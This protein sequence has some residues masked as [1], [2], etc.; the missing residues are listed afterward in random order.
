MEDKVKYSYCIKGSRGGS[1]CILVRVVSSPSAPSPWWDAVTSM[2][3]LA[4][5]DM[6]ASHHSFPNLTAWCER[7]NEF[8]AYRLVHE[9]GGEE[10]T[11]LLGG[12]YS[13]DLGQRG[14]ALS[15]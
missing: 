12:Q 4:E 2:V 9:L 8:S 7:G 6:F 3:Q 10:G 13:L 15:F 5:W 11:F 1:G 14:M